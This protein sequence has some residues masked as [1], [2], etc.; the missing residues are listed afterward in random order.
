MSILSKIF[1]NK[2]SDETAQEPRKLSAQEKSEG[3]ARAIYAKDKVYVPLSAMQADVS[4]GTGIPYIGRLKDGR[5]VLYL[6]DTYEAARA[7][8]DGQ[9]GALNGIGLV[10][11]LDKADQFNIVN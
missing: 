8:S 7:F 6:F 11:A 4:E 5:T 10:G 1:G 2:P 3:A 9:D